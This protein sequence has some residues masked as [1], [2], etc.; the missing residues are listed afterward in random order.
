[1]I[2]LEIDAREMAAIQTELTARPHQ[3]SVALVR[4]INKTLNWARSQGLRS[5]AAEHGIPLKTLRGNKSERRR[6]RGIVRSAIRTNI[7]G[8]VWFGTRP[9]KASYLGTL[10]QQPLGAMAGKHSFPGGFVATMPTGHIGIFR[11][12]GRSRLPIQEEVVRLEA[13]Q[14]A[15]ASV[16]A[17][18]ADRLQ[19]TFLQ[20]LNYEVNVRGQ[21]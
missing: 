14:Q 5:I 1:M 13:T 2:K 11:R 16:M 6:G 8:W 18:V 10:R 4:A 12:S 15:L 19:K 9:I 3:A 17:G 20:E 7:T 21:A